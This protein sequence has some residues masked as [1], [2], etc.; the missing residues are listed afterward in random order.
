[1][2]GSGGMW[3]ADFN[4]QEAKPLPLRPPV[5]RWSYCDD[6]VEQASL[7]KPEAETKFSNQY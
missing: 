1:V 5:A 7:R 3:A 2:K 4:L 6:E